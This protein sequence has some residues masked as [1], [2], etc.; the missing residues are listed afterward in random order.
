M[1]TLRG[2]LR[3]HPIGQGL[4]YT[5]RIQYGKQVPA[6]FFYDCG[7]ST[8]RKHLEQVVGRWKS[9]L[10]LGRIALGI[11]SHLDADHV[12]GLG[13]LLDGSVTCGTVILPYLEPWRRIAIAARSEDAPDEYFEFIEN[14]AQFLL[15]RGVERVVFMG[16]DSNWEDRGE[17]PGPVDGD[18]PPGADNESPR[19]NIRL[20]PWKPQDGAMAGEFV[21]TSQPADLDQSAVS[22]MAGNDRVTFVRDEGH[23]NLSSFWQ[24]YFFQYGFDNGS[25][26]SDADRW[27]SFRSEVAGA[28]GTTDPQF[29]LGRLRNRKIRKRVREAYRHLQKDHNNASIAVWHG[30]VRSQSAARINASGFRIIG[31][32]RADPVELLLEA[33]E[34]R[35]APSLRESY[36]AGQP[37]DLGTLLTGD[38]S[39]KHDFAAFWN[40][41]RPFIQQTSIVSLPHHGSALSWSTDFM[42]NYIASKPGTALFVASAGANNS[43]GHP[44]KA[45]LAD[46]QQRC[47]VAKISELDPGIDVSIECRWA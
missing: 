40:R 25:T 31:Q 12:N 9:E 28:A 33:M 41:F 23:V 21:R 18:G 37:G 44:H 6:Y 30:P 43:Y 38:I 32:R 24:F 19:L 11:I 22:Q 2:D 1:K 36:S 47:P 45:V 7:S 16:G 14:P 10:E 39:L 35:S 5:G 29:I 42:D 15:S 34:G 20:R 3:F 8:D 26:W 27:A 13:V 46:V 17:V 4:F